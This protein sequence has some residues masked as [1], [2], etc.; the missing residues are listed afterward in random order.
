MGCRSSG[1]NLNFIFSLEGPFWTIILRL[2][3]G[4]V[5]VVGFSLFSVKEKR[6]SVENR[7]LGGKPSHRMPG[8]TGSTSGAARRP[9]RSSPQ[10][11]GF[12]AV[13]ALFGGL[14]LSVTWTH[15]SLEPTGVFHTQGSV[16]LLKMELHPL[17]Y[18]PSDPV[19]PNWHPRLPFPSLWHTPL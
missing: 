4:S 2:V 17:L 19:D 7:G 8:G 6:S 9:V 11:P 1:E 10:S 15:T 14:S 3:V 5:E 13:V 18:I 12:S 16:S